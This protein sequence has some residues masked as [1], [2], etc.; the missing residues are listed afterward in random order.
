V[1]DRRGIGRE[2]RREGNL[3]NGE[4]WKKIVEKDRNDGVKK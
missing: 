1:T 3:K 2:R 4:K